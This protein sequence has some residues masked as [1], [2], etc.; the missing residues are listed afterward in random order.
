MKRPDYLTNKLRLSRYNVALS[1]G[2]SS[3][4]ARRIRDWTKRHFVLFL[5]NHIKGIE[6]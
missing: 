6:E 2:I 4:N 1:M 5:Q 3:S